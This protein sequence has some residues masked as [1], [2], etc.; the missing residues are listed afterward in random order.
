MV[1]QSRVSTFPVNTTHKDQCDI[2]P[3]SD[4]RVG[5]SSRGAGTGLKVLRS[6]FRGGKR[7]DLSTGR[8]VQDVTGVVTLVL[9][10]VGGSREAVWVWSRTNLGVEVPGDMVDVVSLSGVC[11]H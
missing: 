1:V 9:F 11:A 2:G 10:L 7:S 8:K 3:T 5:P 6:L 4:D